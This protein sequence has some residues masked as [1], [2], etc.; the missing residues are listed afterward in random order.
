MKSILYIEDEIHFFEF[1]KP[2][3]EKNNI[4]LVHSFNI[5][6]NLESYDAFIVDIFFNKKN[7]GLKICKIIE[8]LKKPIFILSSTEDF[9]IIEKFYRSNFFNFL[10]KK[11]YL[12]YPEKFIQEIQFRIT[13]DQN[14]I[15]LSQDLLTY[16]V[17][18]CRKSLIQI[19][20]HPS[21]LIKGAKNS[22][23]TYFIKKIQKHLPQPFI[24]KNSLFLQESFFESDFFGYKKGSFTG[25]FDGSEG[26]LGKVQNGTL[27]LDDI[28]YLPTILL[29]KI[30]KILKDNY[31]Y[32]IGSLTKKKCQFTLIASSLE[33]SP[34]FFEET[35]F[36]PS[37]KNRKEDISLC[38]HYFLSHLQDPIIFKNCFINYIKENYK[39]EIGDLFHDLRFL[40]NTGKK[41]FYEQDARFI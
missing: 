32:S 39:K 24:E 36:M 25:S 21:L 12:P 13:L 9:S 2:Y 11:T 23:K 28:H 14:A 30:K 7:L 31:Y 26:I 40:Y 35:I 38:F 29:D 27:F 8:K 3:F 37:L 10:Q 17:D 34:D 1:L 22:G 33:T 41:I 6:T 5:P 16:D 18:F 15:L 19:K 20:S 4:T